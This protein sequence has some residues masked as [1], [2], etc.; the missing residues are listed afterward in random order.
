MKR[1]ITSASFHLFS[2]CHDFRSRELERIPLQR[3]TSEVAENTQFSWRGIITVFQGWWESSSLDCPRRCRSCHRFIPKMHR[4]EGSFVPFI[5]LHHSWDQKKTRPK[6]RDPSDV[7]VCFGSSRC[8]KSTLKN[9]V[10]G[11][12][13]QAHWTFNC[14]GNEFR[15]AFCDFHSTTAYVTLDN[16]HDNQIHR[17][18]NLYAIW[19]H[20]STNKPRKVSSRADQLSDFPMDWGSFMGRQT[21]SKQPTNHAW[22][23]LKMA[24][25]K[26]FSLSLSPRNWTPPGTLVHVHNNY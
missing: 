20:Q 19:S 21:T 15:A 26:D 23:I 9:R 17:F 5:W 10:F 14:S 12:T 6:E 16:S 4:W 1:W 22:M 11:T 3:A 2:P 18:P 8:W 7:F 25:S 24:F 13:G